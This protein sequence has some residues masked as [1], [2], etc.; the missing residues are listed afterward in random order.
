L[1]GLTTSEYDHAF[2]RAVADMKAID[3]LN[4]SMK[5]TDKND[6]DIFVIDIGSKTRKF[7][8]MIPDDY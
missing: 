7:S 3:V 4:K 8:K 1:K 5:T 2:A 6:N